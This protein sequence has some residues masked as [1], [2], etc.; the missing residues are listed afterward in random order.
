MPW[1]PSRSH[2]SL[3]T[4][5]CPPATPR[6]NSGRPLRQNDGHYAGVPDQLHRDRRDVES[7]SRCLPV[8]GT[9]RHADSVAEHDLAADDR[10]HAVRDQAADLNGPESAGSAPCS[11]GSTPCCRRWAPAVFL[12]MA[13]H[14]VSH[15]LEAAGTP[16]GSHYRYELAVGCP[17]CRFRPV[18]PGLLPH[19]LRVGA[20]VRRPGAR[21]AAAPVT[22]PEPGPPRAAWPLTAPAYPAEQRSRVRIKRALRPQR[23]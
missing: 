1:S 6:P 8:R 23:A 13:R 14:M 20:L 21:R 5:R 15:H 3:S 19:P 18:D 7:S 10:S 12:A 4:C 22:A 2:C 11:S 16:H 17:G 9:F